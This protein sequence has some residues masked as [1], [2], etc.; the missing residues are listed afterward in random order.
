MSDTEFSENDPSA[1]VYMRPQDRIIST[2]IDWLLPI[3]HHARV[4]PEMFF[5]PIGPIAMVHWLHGLHTGLD[6]WGVTWNDDYRAPAL[7]RRGLE[8]KASLN[9]EDLEA[10][11]LPPAEIVQQILSIEIEMWESHRDA[12]WREARRVSSP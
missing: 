12:I 4:R 8:R 6:F 1:Y 2:A 5:Q 3:L 9:V 11:G 7:E 10:R